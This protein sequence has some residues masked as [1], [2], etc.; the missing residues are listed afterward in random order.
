MRG[1]AIIQN[2]V[3]TIAPYNQ[4][5]ISLYEERNMLIRGTRNEDKEYATIRSATPEEVREFL[6]P[7]AVASTSGINMGTP[8][9]SEMDQL[10]ALFIEQQAKMVALQN[11]LAAAIGKPSPIE[12]PVGKKNKAAINLDKE[13]E[14]ITLPNDTAAALSEILN[15]TEGMQVI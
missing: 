13:P 2:G 1:I 6:L 11:A 12:T 9:S 4:S 5:V 10:R 3:T 14:T 8:A 7:E 15:S